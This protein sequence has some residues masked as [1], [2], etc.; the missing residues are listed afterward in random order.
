FRPAVVT[1]PAILTLIILIGR[2]LAGLVRMTWR[3]PVAMLAVVAPGVL[4]IL[5]GWQT[6]FLVTS[7]FPVGLSAWALTDRD[8]FVRVVGRR[9]QAWWRL[10]WIYRR[11]W[12]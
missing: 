2:G 10:I 11:H 3:H 4:S 6:A 1:T 9:L 8:S 7:P 12:Q 5:Y